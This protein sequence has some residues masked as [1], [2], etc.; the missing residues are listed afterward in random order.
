MSRIYLTNLIIFKFHSC[1]KLH[2]IFIISI[3]IYLNNSDKQFDDI[4]QLLDYHCMIAKRN[5]CHTDSEINRTFNVKCQ[6]VQM[7]S[8]DHPYKLCTLTVEQTVV[9]GSLTV[10]K[11]TSPLSKNKNV[12]NYAQRCQ[13]ETED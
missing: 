3:F 6:Y 11:R 5:T 4:I 1:N 8:N 2:F 7:W 12:L 9:T 13:R 10:P